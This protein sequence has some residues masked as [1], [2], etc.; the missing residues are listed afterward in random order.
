[1][2]FFCWD[3][4]NSGQSASQRQLT[5][6]SLRQTEEVEIRL[7]TF[8]KKIAENLVRRLLFLMGKVQRLRQCNMPIS[9]FLLYRNRYIY[10]VTCSKQPTTF[11][12]KYVAQ[13]MCYQVI[14]MLV[15]KQK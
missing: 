12:S 10:V 8:T 11:S 15:V 2:H 7:L 6:S 4:T 9:A 13:T 5:K 1:M 3:Q 14:C